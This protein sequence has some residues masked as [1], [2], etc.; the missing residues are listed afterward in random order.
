MSLEM[1]EIIAK[2]MNVAEHI[3]NWKQYSPFETLIR[4]ILSQNT[5]DKNA[6][7]AFDNL[8]A[9]FN[10]Q[11]NPETL[12]YADTAKIQDAIRVAGLHNQKSQRIKEVSKIIYFNWK[13]DFSFI[14]KA[15]LQNARKKLTE[16]PGI[17]KKTADV[18]LNFCAK[19]PIL[20]VDTHITR[21]SKRIGLV[22]EK[23]K[24]DE[25]RHSIEALIPND[26]ILYIHVALI[27]FGRKI[28]K[29]TV[30]ICSSCPINHLCPKNGVKKSK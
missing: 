10:N 28:C 5:T 9:K 17:G 19:R 21:I 26:K 25:I 8:K 6:F 4:T 1:L 15:P 29:A 23:A 11:I 2:E 16:L 13:S 22:S 27:F 12:A 24:Y 14:Y 18:L 30:P 7:A 20:P 3:R